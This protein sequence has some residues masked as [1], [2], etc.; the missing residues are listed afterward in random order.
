MR[1]DKDEAEICGCFKEWIESSDNGRA[2]WRDPKSGPEASK[3]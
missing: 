3:A 1:V 2:P